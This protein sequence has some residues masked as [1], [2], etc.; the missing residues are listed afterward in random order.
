MTA[1][2]RSTKPNICQYCGKGFQDRFDLKRHIRTHTGVRPYRCD[3]CPRAFTQRCSLETHAS[4]VH[5]SKQDFAFK[6]RRK[7]LHI[8]EQCGH[9]EAEAKAHYIHMWTEHGLLEMPKR[10]LRKLLKQV[11]RK[12]GIKQSIKKDI[13]SNKYLISQAMNILNELG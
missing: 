8:C 10:Q 2:H 3:L 1:I 12:I 4:N 7:K 11:S 13:M 5:G 9:S 6:Q